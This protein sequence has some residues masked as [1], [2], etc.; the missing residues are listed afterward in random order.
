MAGQT[1]CLGGLLQ[2]EQ[3][4]QVELIP[5]LG[6]LPLIGKPGSEQGEVV[7]RPGM[8]MCVEPTI[9]GMDGDDE[10]RSGLFTAE[11]QVVVTESGVE[12][13]TVQIPRTLVRR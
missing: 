11:D 12:V 13:L 2:T 1:L 8:V 10:W 7:A 6:E 5:V 9:V 3:E 4:A